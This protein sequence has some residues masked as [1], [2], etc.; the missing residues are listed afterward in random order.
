MSE[1]YVIERFV[2]TVAQQSVCV[3]VLYARNRTKVLYARN[4]TGTPFTDVLK[5]TPRIR[6]PGF[7]NCMQ[8]CLVVSCPCRC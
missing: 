7:S 6:F 3:K 4:K 8:D 5:S 1:C 2:G